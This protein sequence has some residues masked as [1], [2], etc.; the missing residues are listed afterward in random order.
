M[1]F[2]VLVRVP[3]FNSSVE[4]PGINSWHLDSCG[5]RK[6][7][8]I[9]AFPEGLER[10]ASRPQSLYQDLVAWLKEWLA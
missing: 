10:L 4:H 2:L 7:N 6:N 1:T 8:L 9:R 3:L 5:R